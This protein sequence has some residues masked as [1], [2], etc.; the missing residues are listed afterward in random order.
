MHHFFADGSQLY[1]FFKVRSPESLQQAICGT[2]I[3]VAAAQ[4]WM[5]SNKLKCNAEKTE[6]IMFA[7]S[8]SAPLNQVSISIR[9]TEVGG[10]D[11]VRNLGLY[12]DNQLTMER[13]VNFICRSANFHLCRIGSIRRYLTTDSWKSLVHAL[14]MSRLDYCNNLLYGLS[15]TLM[16]RMQRVQNKAARNVSRVPCHEHISL[17][18]CKLHWLLPICA[19]VDCKVLL[20]TYK[21]LHETAPA[22]LKRAGGEA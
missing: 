20:Y 18:L 22:Y 10:S 21:T 14:V 5:L 11:C 4:E 16:D 2:E 1:R 9:G 3:S 13:H 17:T 15:K 6:M 19:R 12:Q 7:P 8:R